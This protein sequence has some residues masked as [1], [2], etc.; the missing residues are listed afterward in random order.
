MEKVWNRIRNTPGSALLRQGCWIP[1]DRNYLT[2][3]RDL[4]K[5]LPREDF[6]LRHPIGDLSL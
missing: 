2:G 4:V 3:F 1:F 6:G 5:D